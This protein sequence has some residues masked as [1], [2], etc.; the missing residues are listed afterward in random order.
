M[1]SHNS[2]SRVNPLV[3]A[4]SLAAAAFALPS[5]KP[6]APAAALPDPAR[7]QGEQ[8]LAEVRGFLAIGPR[9]SGTDGA[10]RGAEYLRDRLRALG[11]AAEIDEFREAAPG[12]TQVFRNVVG[13]IPG[14][15]PDCVVVACHYDTKTGIAPDFVGANDGGSGVG[16][17]LEIA[18]LRRGAARPAPCEIQLAFVDGEECVREYGPHDGLHGSRRLAA[19]LA[20]EGP[21][22]VRAVVVVDMIGDRDLTVTIPRNGTPALVSK[23]FA[24]AEAEGARTRFSWHPGGMLDDH[25]PFLD[26]GLPAVDLIDFEYGSAPG[27]NDY[28]HT[29]EDTIDK[30]SAASLQT[31]GRVVVRV[32]DSVMTDAL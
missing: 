22:R 3:A 31:V 7:F 10:R 2:R 4:A 18:A 12:G 6:T 11:V 24:A 9:D 8:A 17:E 27:R 21:E 29:R 14:A 16:V 25:V 5:C 20:A 19:R 30:L 15:G 23:V 1:K 13:R 28:W 26:A 32:I